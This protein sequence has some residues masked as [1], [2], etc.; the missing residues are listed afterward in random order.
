MPSA[1]NNGEGGSPLMSNITDRRETAANLLE[2][3]SPLAGDVNARLKG[4]PMIPLHRDTVAAIVRYLLAEKHE[5]RIVGYPIPGWRLDYVQWDE[6]EG[7]P[8]GWIV[9]LK[10]ETPN[11]AEHRRSFCVM[12]R[13]DLGPLEAWDEALR[14]ARRED[15][16]EAER[17]AQK[18]L[19]DSS[20]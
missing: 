5:S 1:I 2:L 10:R 7:Q 8:D 13:S 4:T 9:S 17:S 18:P 11:W 20:Q 3:L 19:A 16:R 15:E 14:I 6:R 12:S